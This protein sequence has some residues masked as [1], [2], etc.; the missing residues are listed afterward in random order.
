MLFP[1]LILALLDGSFFFSVLPLSFDEFQGDFD[2]VL[3]SQRNK[4]S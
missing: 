3:A 2:S 4:N 1:E